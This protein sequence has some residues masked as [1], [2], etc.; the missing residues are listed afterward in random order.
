MA[1]AAAGTTGAAD[2]FT[3]LIRNHPQ[4][5][6]AIMTLNG[7]AVWTLSFDAPAR[8]SSGWHAAQV[9]RRVGSCA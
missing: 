1:T 2:S 5:G 6:V 8:A 3:G 9:M 4:L 7:D